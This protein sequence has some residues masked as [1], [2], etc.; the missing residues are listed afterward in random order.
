MEHIGVATRI[1][2]VVHPSG[3]EEQKMKC[4]VRC[5]SEAVTRCRIANTTANLEILAV[6][7]ENVEDNGGQLL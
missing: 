2:A 4:I 5:S 1:L 7:E 6:L 3:T